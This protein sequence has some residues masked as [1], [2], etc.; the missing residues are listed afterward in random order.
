MAVGSGDGHGSG[1]GDPPLSSEDQP[2]H[3]MWVGA[4]S[5]AHS[6]SHSCPSACGH[7]YWDAPVS[8]CFSEG[9]SE[10]HWHP[11]HWM[12]RLFCE[13]GAPGRLSSER[14]STWQAEGM[15]VGG[16]GWASSPL[17]TS[18]TRQGPSG[19]GSG[20]FSPWDEWLR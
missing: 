10:I 19:M 1:K 16:Q 20:L 4:T 9:Q 14:R 11:G 5:S 17:E 15:S 13:H 3:R 18:N 12:H 6:C 7:T 8:L 2:R